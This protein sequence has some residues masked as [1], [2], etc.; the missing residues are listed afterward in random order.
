[1]QMNMRCIARSAVQKTQRF[2]Q[3]TQV[4]RT[5]EFFSPFEGVAESG[6]VSKNDASAA[7]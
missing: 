6:G 3:P 7:G 1:M 5:L 2:G 4:S